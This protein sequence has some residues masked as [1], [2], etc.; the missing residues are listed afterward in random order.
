[1]E[2]RGQAHLV[3]P[4]ALLGAIA[5]WGFVPVA[6]RYLLAYFSP[7]QL[8]A[9]RFGLGAVFVVLI[10][11]TI[12][13]RL[14]PRRR[15]RQTIALGMFATLGYNVLLAFGI[16]RIEAGTAAL[17]NGTQPVLIALLAA[18]VL[19]EHLSKRMTIGTLVA[20]VGSALIALTAESGF[21]FTGSYVFGCVLV[22]L[23]SVVWATYSVIA[24]PRFGP[25]MPPSS[26][27]LLGVLCAAPLIVPFGVAGTSD[28]LG[29]LTWPGWLAIALLA[30]GANVTAP[31]LF[32][33]GLQRGQA[34]NAGFMLFLVPLIGVSSSV[35]LLDE[36]LAPTHVIG[37]ALIIVGVA[38]ATFSPA[39]LVLLHLRRAPQRA[40]RP[41][42]DLAE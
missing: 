3:G 33:I 6:T 5:F 24:K 14:P 34:S 16:Q 29:E 18:I 13:P 22:L 10:L 42:A 2:R 40:E 11:A 31:A 7:A 23:T 19:G 4:L 12:R 41:S 17:L 38:I 39:W 28:G 32:N 15:L 26:V 1:M 36:R 27:A 35:A 9:L 37:G 21:R 30:F 20:L 8:L 25:E